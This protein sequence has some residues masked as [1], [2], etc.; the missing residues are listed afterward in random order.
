VLH[1]SLSTTINKIFNFICSETLGLA[2]SCL[3][4][5]V[6]SISQLFTVEGKELF[7]LFFFGGGGAVVD[8]FILVLQSCTHLLTVSPVNKVI[9]TTLHGAKSEFCRTYVLCRVCSLS[10]R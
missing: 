7:A 9:Y 1:L 6:S 10:G 5:N 8:S 3:C 4:T 2:D